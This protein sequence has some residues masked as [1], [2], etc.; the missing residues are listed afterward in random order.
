MIDRVVRKPAKTRFRWL[1]VCAVWLSASAA[2]ACST[3]AIGPADARLVAY[4][5]DT[6]V[7]GAG[8][9]FVNPHGAR[10]TS[11][12]E[13]EPAGWDVAHGSITFNQ[14]GFGMPTT[15]VNTAGLVVSLMWNDKA[16]FPPVAGRP[17]VSE[18][19]FIQ[20]L[21][22][23]AGSVDE[24]TTIMD[25]FAIQAL[26]PIHFFLADASGATA[27]ITPTRQALVVHTGADMPV[28]ALTNTSYAELVDRLSGLAGF[29]G[30]APAPPA[31]TLDERGSLARFAI[32]AQAI[33]NGSS[34]SGKADAFAVLDRVENR[35]TRWQIVY[36]PQDREIDFRLTGRAGQWRIDMAGI[37]FACGATPLGRSLN[38]L[39]TDE[40]I[41]VFQPIAVSPV[42]A[43]VSD[44]LDGFAGA[45][46]LPPEAAGS[47]VEA[48]L[49]SFACA[50]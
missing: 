7:T 28:R 6:S 46:G 39:A 22:D 44:V 37:D 47:I 19:E 16:V 42:V 36:V 23:R 35:Q 25:E 11:I 34:P 21:L 3:V 1:L 41:P 13:D 33:K 43:V 9:V 29:G 31:G 32:A 24:A 17:I 40:A 15:G 48:Q 50:E 5:Y 30:E 2:L 8:F 49:A 26:V 12:M 38:N 27:A 45:L 20:M 10:R 14:M 18:L 4:S